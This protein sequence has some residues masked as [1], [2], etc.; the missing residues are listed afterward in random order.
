MN[1]MPDTAIKQ[2]LIGAVALVLICLSGCTQAHSSKKV[3]TEKNLAAQLV[4]TSEIHIVFAQSYAFGYRDSALNNGQPEKEIDCIVTQITPELMMPL[5]ADVFDKKCS[6]DE[7]R[8][9]AIKFYESET[10]KTYIRN[11]KMKMK[12]VLGMSTEEPPEYSRSDEDRIVAFEQTLVGKL[13]TSQDK[14]LREAL[15]EAIRPKLF[16]IIDQCKKAQ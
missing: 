1:E 4:E 15:K 6:D 14:S 10:G 9:Q 12:L 8:Q 16:A 11:E 5:L 13:V 2:L 7:L 3:V